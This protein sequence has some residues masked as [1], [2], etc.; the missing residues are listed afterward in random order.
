MSSPAEELFA[1]LQ[2]D[3]KELR[4]N[5]ILTSIAGIALTLGIIAQ[6]NEWDKWLEYL[7]FAIAFLA[8]GTQA[9]ISA[10]TQLLKGKLDIDLLMVLA[11][12]AAAAVGE[13]RDG[14]I[15]LFL[16]SLAGTLE[17]YAMGNTK[18][19]VASL[20]ELR[21]DTAHLRLADGSL[22]EIDVEE[23]KLNDIVVI[24]P[25]ERIPVDATIISGQSAIDQAAVTGE[26]V[27]VDKQANDKVFA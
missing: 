22:K 24:K 19:A 4:L 13:A 3:K 17:H 14:A 20:M 16:F 12:L 9:A 2:E 21:P 26:S 5:I 15:L 23:L 27:P 8:G 10:T 6:F 1:E 18:R 7:A 25:S 11:A